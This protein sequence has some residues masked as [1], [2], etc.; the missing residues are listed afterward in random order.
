MGKPINKDK[1]MPAAQRVFIRYGYKRTT[2]GDIAEA[3]G[4]SR[5]ALYLLYSSKEEV[6]AAT[7][8]QIFTE[9]LNI[10]RKGIHNHITIHDQLI[11]AFDVWCVEPYKMTITHPDAKDLLESSY[12]FASEVSRKAWSGFESILT[13]ILE[14]TDISKNK[15][16]DAAKIA[17]IMA[18]ATSG[19]K[20]AASSVAE[21]RRIIK[22]FLTLV[23]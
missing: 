13:E 22:D 14:S 4:I 3:A 7:L 12:I 1:I 20:E 11:F 19:F 10:I 2:M 16:L 6:F 23:N 5:P 17:H 8:E 15:S 21:L 18:A 9:Q